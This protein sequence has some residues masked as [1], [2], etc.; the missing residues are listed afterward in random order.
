MGLGL[1][2]LGVILFS[3]ALFSACG[4]TKDT[5]RRVGDGHFPGFERPPGK[6]QDPDVLQLTPEELKISH[7]SQPVK[8][9]VMNHEGEPGEYTKIQKKFVFPIQ[10]DGWV[11]VEGVEHNYLRC[12]RGVGQEPQFILE[13]DLNGSVVVTVGEK[14]PVQL[15]KIYRLKLEFL[16]E[17]LCKGLDIQF[18]VLYGYAD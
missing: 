17:S 3:I 15:E 9:N 10:F 7:F 12:A 13:D 6:P 11:M 14:I 16:N 2:R 18:G 5:N 1:G 8:L 4:A